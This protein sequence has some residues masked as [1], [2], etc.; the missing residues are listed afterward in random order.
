MNSM[1][2]TYGMNGI[3]YST[4]RLE[5]IKNSNPHVPHAPQVRQSGSVL[6][7]SQLC[8]KFSLSPCGRGIKGEG[9]SGSSHPRT[10]KN[11]NPV[12]PGFWFLLSKDCIVPPQAG[13]TMS[14]I[15]QVN[16]VHVTAVPAAG[17]HSWSRFFLLRLLSYQSFGGNQKRSNGSGIL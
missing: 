14:F 8:K 13:L 3:A 17:W 9:D 4:K 2:H 1:V 6:K 15:W 5:K 7:G 11:Q 12:S 16:L 10:T